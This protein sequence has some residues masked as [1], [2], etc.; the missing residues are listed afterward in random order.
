MTMTKA[1][2]SYP[3][4]AYCQFWHADAMLSLRIN[5]GNKKLHIMMRFLNVVWASWPWM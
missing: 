4:Q 1:S 2:V 3:K 5:H